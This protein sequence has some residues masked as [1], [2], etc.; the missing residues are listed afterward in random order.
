[1]SRESIDRRSA[2]N[3][4]L[5]VAFDE[6][7]ATLERREGD[8]V[9]RLALRTCAEEARRREIP[10]E[11]FLA[12]LKRLLDSRPEIVQRLTA[13]ARFHRRG[14]AFDEIV[15]WAIEDYYGVPP[16]PAANG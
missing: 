8:A 1:M 12:T 4:A 3:E 16:R 5:R 11:R 9:A 7:I 6:L 15:T 14:S 13:L 10:P 2:Q